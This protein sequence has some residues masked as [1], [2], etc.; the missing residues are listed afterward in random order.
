MALPLKPRS[1]FSTLSEI[2]VPGAG[3]CI[4]IGCGHAPHAACI[5]AA[6]YD[7]FGLDLRAYTQISVHGS[8]LALPFRDECCDAVVTWQ[9]LEHF[10]N[11][12]LSVKEM[13]RIIKPGGKIFG[14]TS[15]LEPYHD[16]SYFGFSPLGLEYLLCENGFSDVE[17]F[18]G[19]NCFPLVNWTLA[20]RMG[21][22]KFAAFSFRASGLILDLITRC[23]P[24]ARN[25]LM[26][27]TNAQGGSVEQSYWF[28]HVPF[29]F[30]GH[31][32]FRA[33]KPNE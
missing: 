4:D 29:E 33:Q 13:Y 2:L 23:Y 25:L 31:L 9:S 32:M 10:P 27:L 28:L 1:N 5:A 18:P 22:G 30:A 20:A 11:P 19:I 26:K 8:A 7:W 15:F 3:I 6:G 21:G 17:I 14:S 24:F 12:W 16:S